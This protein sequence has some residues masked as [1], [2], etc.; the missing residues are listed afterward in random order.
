MGAGRQPADGLWR[1]DR[2]GLFLGCRSRA[3]GRGV[4]TVDRGR[5]WDGTHMATEAEIDRLISRL[6]TYQTRA[7][8]RRRLRQLGEQ[9]GEKLT[10]VLD[11]EDAAPNKRWAAIS[12]L[13]DCGY[14]P[15]G[16]ALLR[17]M[18]ADETL[19][20]DTCRA[21]RTITGH[22]IGDDIAAWEQALSGI[23]A[24]DETPAGDAGVPGPN[25]DSPELDLVREA[26]GDVATVLNWEEP[27]YAYLRL[28]VG[29]DRKQQVIV[30]FD[31][32][33]RDGNPLASVYTECG[34]ASPEAR[35][36][37]SHRN[38]TLPY[39]K[40]AVEEDEGV[41]KVVM[42]HYERLDRLTADLLR[43]M[44]LAMARE[45]DNL[46]YELTQGG[47]RI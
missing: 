23:G 32:A 42:R 21:L 20:G 36:T 12:L 2:R 8:A 27:G 1:D 37:I 31:E 47:D 3:P 35:Q 45:A 41:E 24:A 10:A 14:E 38:V 33:D 6:G 34:P 44:I 16:P 46:E 19:I 17:T 28:P 5:N 39:G 15:A 13:A 26:L 18:K 29:T 11:E 30:T 25:G 9:A 43:D 22:D 7:Q 4:G 40:F